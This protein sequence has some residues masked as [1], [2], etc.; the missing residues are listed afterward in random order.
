MR[1]QSTGF[2]A[3]RAVWPLAVLCAVL[4]GLAARAAERGFPLITV[5]PAET[6]KGGPQTFDIAQDPRGVLYFGNLHGL[7]T[8]DG[9]WWRMMKLPD[10]QVALSVAADARGRVVLGMVNDAG[11]LAHDATGTPEFH[12]LLPQLPPAQRELGDVRAVCTTAEGFLFVT[13]RSLLLWDGTRARVAAQIDPEKG[14][15]GCYSDDEGVYVH[16]PNGLQR[17][18]PRTAALGPSLVSGRVD[19]VLRNGNALLAAVRDSGFFTIDHSSNHTVVTPFSPAASE[20]MKKKFITGGCRLGDGRLVFATRE[21][22]IVIVDANGEIEQFITDAAGLPDAVITEA[23]V[24]HEGSVWLAMEGPITRIDVAS[25][26]SI[27]DARRGLKGGISDIARFRNHVYVASTH[28]LHRIDEHGVVQRIEGI[29]DAWRVLPVDDELLIGTSRGMYRLRENGV[30][31]HFYEREGE[32]YDLY[33]S[34]ADPSR[35]WI[36]QR[37][38]LGSIRR[39]GGKWIYEDVVPGVPEYV[40]SVIEQ[41]GEVWAGTVFNGFVRVRDPRGAK[42]RVKEFGAGETNVF[43]VAGRVVA[44]RATGAIYSVDRNDR[45]VVDPLLGHIHEPRGFFVLVEDTSGDVWIN[46]I[47]PRVFERRADGTYAR[48]GRPLVSVTASDIQTLRAD[49]GGVVWFASDKGLFRYEP[50]TATATAAAQPAPLIRRVAAGERVLLGGDAQARPRLTLSH[51]FGRLRIEFAP[52]SYRPGVEYQYRLDPIDEEWS[53]WTE[54][55][56][57]D[58]TTLEAND[59]TFRLRARGPSLMPSAERRW[60]FSVLPPWYRT[61]WAYALWA[62]LAMAVIALVT[63]TRTAALRRQTERLRQRVAEKTAELQETVKLLEQAN[64]RLEVLS[65]EDDLTGI[66]NRRYFERALADEWNRARRRE[67]PLAL[68]LLDLDHFKMLNDRRGHPAGDE[69]LRRVGKFLADSVKRSGEVVAR[70]G[71]EE[72]AILLPG[73]D[74]DGAIRVAEGLR[75]GIEQL[76]N[77][78]A[79]C[80]VA[81]MIPQADSPEHL[82]ASADRALYAAKHSGRNCVRVADERSTGTWLRD[83]SAS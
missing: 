6:H 5:Y 53:R 11:Y 67:H 12:S 35:V 34:P 25:P 43:Q 58:Y 24:D 50:P 37:H 45:V 40:S 31:E 80:G 78:T 59:Y 51:K 66:A 49:A 22:G 9:A 20:W 28:G 27:F 3:S 60:T 30:P 36:A 13:E 71:G 79:S 63:I 14:P 4:C 55:P 68:V 73:V 21:N 39:E 7:M 57:I 70:Y 72:F 42:P 41:N 17:F 19:L 29:R 52:A 77:V 15:R 10:D 54:Q 8:Y 26:V 46:S 33:R 64:S 1:A 18:D 48:E 75:E 47:P 2:T 61:A 32:I 76:G 23:L 69:C 82:V 56:F 83:A 81:A 38:G 62:L 16:G 74:A 65:L 44:V